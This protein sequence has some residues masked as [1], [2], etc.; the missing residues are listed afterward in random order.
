M[1]GRLSAKLRSCDGGF[2]HWCPGCDQP[3]RINVTKENLPKWTWN[4][5]VE[6]PVCAPSVR[7]FTTDPETKKQKTLCHYFLG[8]S[9]GDKPGRIEF[10]GDSPHEFSGQTVDLPD[11]PESWS[12]D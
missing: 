1:M 10:C 11:W 5:D 9:A 4:G 3:H 2:F 12:D 8:G 7:C 6:R